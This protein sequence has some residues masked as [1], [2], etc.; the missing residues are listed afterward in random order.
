P[1]P[2]TLRPSLSL[3]AVALSPP[4]RPSLL[5]LLPVAAF[6]LTPCSPP[7]PPLPVSL[8]AFLAAVA[9]AP[10]TPAGSRSRAGVRLGVA[11]MAGGYGGT[12]PSVAGLNTRRPR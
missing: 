2:C 1:S 4:R 12:R 5:L 9:A 6:S 8:P 11:G 7:P 3:H 10:S